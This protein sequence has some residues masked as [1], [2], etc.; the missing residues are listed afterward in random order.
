MFT[1]IFI[2]V[3]LSVGILLLWNHKKISFAIALCFIGIFALLVVSFPIIASYNKVVGDADTVAKYADARICHDESTNE[4]FIIEQTL[5]NPIVHY[6]RHDADQNEL[7]ELVEAYEAA[8]KI[9]YTN[10]I[11][12]TEQQKD[13]TFQVVSF[14]LLR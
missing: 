1:N 8:Q 5:W 2:Y 10:I 13:T 7:I 12:E 4:Y 11:P 14:V 9:P 6:V 3:A